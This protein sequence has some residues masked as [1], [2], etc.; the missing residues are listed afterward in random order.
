VK[1]DKP[2]AKAR[3]GGSAKMPRL[4][5]AKVREGVS[6]IVQELGMVLEHFGSAA[7][8]IVK[9]WPAQIAEE[10]STACDAARDANEYAFKLER[11]IESVAVTANKVAKQ[12]RKKKSGKGRR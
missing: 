2:I 4:D 11:Y 9:N 12:Q 8:P 6:D 7:S 3:K 5:I 1:A 10:L